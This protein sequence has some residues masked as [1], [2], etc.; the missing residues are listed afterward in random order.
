M[1]RG[2]GPDEPDDDD[3]GPRLT[4]EVIFKKIERQMIGAMHLQIAVAGKYPSV[5]QF[6]T[7]INFSITSGDMSAGKSTLIGVLLSGKLDNGKG[8]ARTHVS[9][10]NISSY[11]NFYDIFLVRYSVIIT[12][13]NREP[14][15][16]CLTTQSSSA[17][18]ERSALNTIEICFYIF[19]N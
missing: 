8:L 19:I 16:V 17:S 12:K 5:I 9:S 14:H 13:F 11:C 2:H 7:S 3:G 15:R 6:N 4:A 1:G 18:M 10:Q